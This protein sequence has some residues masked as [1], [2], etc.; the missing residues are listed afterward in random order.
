MLRI[1]NSNQT[2]LYISFSI[3]GIQGFTTHMQVELSGHNSTSLSASLSCK[4]AVMHTPRTRKPSMQSSNSFLMPFF[5]RT[6]KSPQGVDCAGW[7]V[8]AAHSQ[9]PEALYAQGSPLV[10]WQEKSKA[11]VG[12]CFVTQLATSSFMMGMSVAP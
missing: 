12:T 5:L 8:S 1:K 10:S 9:L 4:R 11:K 6:S 7:I 2:N 3:W